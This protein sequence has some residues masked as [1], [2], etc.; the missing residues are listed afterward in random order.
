MAKKKRAVWEKRIYA[1]IIAA[2]VIAFWRGLWGLMDIYL[3][4]D[5][6]A[7]SLWISLIAGLV[8]LFILHKV[9]GEL[10]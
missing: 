5:N 3:F 10:I 4:P 1:V 9:M 7:L 2:A 8:I 6:Y